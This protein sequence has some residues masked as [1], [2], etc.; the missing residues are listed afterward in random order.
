MKKYFS[1]REISAELGIPKSTVVKY[2][3]YFSDFLKMSGDGKR[4]KFDESALDVLKSIRDLR[5]NQ[6]LDW[7]EI[8]DILLKEYGEPE[9]EPNT[10][11]AITAQQAVSNSAAA[12]AISPK[13]DYITHMV[14]ILGSQTIEINAELE[15]AKK[16]GGR[17]NKNTVVLARRLVQV[18]RKLDLVIGELLN[19]DDRQLKDLKL[20]ASGMRKEFDRVNVMLQRLAEEVAETKKTPPEEAETFSQMKQLVDRLT[21]DGASF[22]NKYQVAQREN[23]ILKNKIRELTYKQEQKV[24]DSPRRGGGLRGMFKRA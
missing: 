2:K 19:R 4:K 7:L 10:S 23:E 15:K 6:R 16:S 11:V 3:D 22:Q 1:L 18:E 5:E 9:S 8:K 24:E 13:I 12:V 20:V 21:K 14:T 17:N